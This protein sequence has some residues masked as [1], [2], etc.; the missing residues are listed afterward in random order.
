VRLSH[1]L[2]LIKSMNT[3]RRAYNF[4]AAMPNKFTLRSDLALRR[5]S[6][7]GF[8]RHRTTLLADTSR[9]TKVEAEI[10]FIVLREK[11]NP[12]PALIDGPACYQIIA[13]VA[14]PVTK[15]LDAV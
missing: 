4:V 5:G 6:P 13:Q 11:G 15:L 10:S 12:N 8:G 2:A 3:R 7:G 14:H 9:K 1:S